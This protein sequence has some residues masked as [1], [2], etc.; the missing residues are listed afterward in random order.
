VKVWPRQ[1]RPREISTGAVAPEIMGITI[2]GGNR[3]ASL[4]SVSARKGF[5]GSNPLISANEF[6]T[7][8][9]L[10]RNARNPLC[11]QL[12]DAPHRT[13]GSHISHTW[14]ATNEISLRFEFARLSL[15]E[16]LSERK[17]QQAREASAACRDEPTRTAACTISG[18]PRDPDLNAINTRIRIPG[19]TG[20]RATNGKE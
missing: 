16:T 14:P 1:T 20:C 18:Q 6:L 9:I 11:V 7:S 13:R 17:S 2:T 4:V 3:C 15:L 8:D 5:P 19:D 12:F 10:Q